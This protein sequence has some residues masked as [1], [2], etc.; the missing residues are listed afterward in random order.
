MQGTG[1]Y[2]EE[3]YVR[4]ITVLSGAGED[5]SNQTRTRIVFSDSGKVYI[6][7]QDWKNIACFVY[8]VRPTVDEVV[9]LCQAIMTNNSDLDGVSV[10]AR[11]V[12]ASLFPEGCANSTNHSTQFCAL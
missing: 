2:A 11:M 3:G 5:R 4:T 9:A 7:V 10:M 6:L 12:G 8:R 1:V